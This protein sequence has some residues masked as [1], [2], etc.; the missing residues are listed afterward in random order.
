MTNSRI[1]RI[2][3]GLL[4]L[5]LAIPV[6][7]GLIVVGF[8]YTPLGLMFILHLIT[9][10]LSLNNREPIYGSVFGIVT[11]ALAWIP[12]LGWIMHLV[13]AILLLISAAQKGHTGSRRTF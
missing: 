3:T 12:V 4:E 11:S 1:L 2:L 5:I 6:L 7:G 13:S 9:L 8:S 10:V